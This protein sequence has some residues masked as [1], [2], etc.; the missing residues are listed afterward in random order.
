M[1]SLQ[2]YLLFSSDRGGM[3]IEYAKHKMGEN[4]NSGGL[5]NN[6]MMNGLPANNLGTNCT[7]NI[8]QNQ[9]MNSVQNSG[10]HHIPTGGNINV[11]SSCA[12]PVTTT[13]ATNHHVNHVNNHVQH[14]KSTQSNQTNSINN[15]INA[16]GTIVNTTVTPITNQ[17]NGAIITHSQINTNEPMEM[18]V[19]SIEQCQYMLVNY[20]NRLDFIIYVTLFFFEKKGKKII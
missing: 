20:A 19:P 11:P 18:V 13:I 12:T 6:G 10:H 16:I 15:N 7:N 2:N 3:R 1:N 4:T 17:P 14:T 5:M 9:I 8:G